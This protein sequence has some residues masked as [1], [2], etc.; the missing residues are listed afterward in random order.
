MRK[1]LANTLHQLA[2]RDPDT[3]HP[4]LAVY[5]LTYACDF[6]CPYC[7]DGNQTPYY[8]L[9]RE[10]LSA[11]D[12]LQVLAQIR[13]VCDHLVLT[14]GEPTQHPELD[15]VLQRLPQLGFDGVVFTTNGFD[16]RPHLSAVE[17]SVDY[18]VFSLDTLDPERADR[19]FGVG[20]GTLKRILANIDEASRASKLPYEIIISSV[21]TPGNIPDLYGVYKYAKARGFRFAACPQLQGVKAPAALI[22]NADYEAFFQH[23]IGEKLNG[24]SINGSVAYLEHLRDFRQFQCRPST[25]L[26][27]SPG[28]DVFYPCLEQ[29]KVAGNLLAT[30]DLNA[31]RRQGKAR[32]GPEPNCDNRCHSACALGLSLALNQ[33]TSALHEALL[34]GRNAVGRLL[35]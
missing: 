7:S 25:V 30:P 31:I 21:V 5:Y 29:G 13:K 9:R 20:E 32:F 6:R 16:I 26:A 2:Q 8:Q 24:G 15:E 19:S 34:Q 33:P 10:R 22:G 28:G 11:A 17:K 18:L 4:L 23:L 3:W 14:G 1:A 35:G 12:V 27:V